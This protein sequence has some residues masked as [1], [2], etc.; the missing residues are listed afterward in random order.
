MTNHLHQSF[1]GI[2]RPVQ[3]EFHKSNIK[4]LPESTFKSLLNYI[5][6][7][8]TI[9]I[10]KKPYHNHNNHYRYVIDSN[11]YS[12]ID[13]LDCRNL[14]LIRDNYVIPNLRCSSNTGFTLFSIETELYFKSKCN[15]T[16]A[17]KTKS[18]IKYFPCE[19]HL[20]NVRIILLKYLIIN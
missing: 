16:F 7:N 4:I 17:S 20:G 1:Y 19:Y 12:L 9:T 6:N 14:W 8:N 2:Q 15:L 3:I 5:N 11:D 10:S 18:E 13:C